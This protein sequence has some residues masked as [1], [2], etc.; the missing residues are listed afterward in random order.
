MKKSFLYRAAVATLVVGLTLS[1]SACGEETDVDTPR[2]LYTLSDAIPEP[3]TVT[4]DGE[5]GGLTLDLTP[6]PIEPGVTTEVIQEIL[7]QNLFTL[8]VQNDVSGVSYEISQGD[9]VSGEPTTVGEYSVGTCC[10]MVDNKWVTGRLQFF[11]SFNDSTIKLDGDYSAT[12][13]VLENGYF[14][15]ESFTRQVTV[16]AP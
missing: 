5:L 11:N 8:T 13:T 3:A 2:T 9:L 10:K 16:T 4:I 1:F 12:I 14:V 7:A 15:P 6:Y